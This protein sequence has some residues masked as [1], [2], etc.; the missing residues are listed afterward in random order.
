MTSIADGSVHIQTFVE[1]FPSTPS[2]FGEVVPIVEYLRKQGILS[3]ISERVR[4]ARRRFGHYEVI[5][6]VAVLFG[7]AV[8]SERTLEAFYEH[9]HP[10][11]PAFMALSD[12]IAC[13]PVRHS[14]AF[15][16]L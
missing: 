15:W 6:F 1:S 10:F 9:L 13:L 8:S 7:Y 3:K 14:R 5:D 16:Q 4:F 11:A 12:E 2:W